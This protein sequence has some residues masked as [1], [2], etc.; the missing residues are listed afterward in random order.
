MCCNPLVTR[1]ATACKP[2]SVTRPKTF[3]RHI[4]ELCSTIGKRLLDEH[5]VLYVSGRQLET[6]I[7]GTRP[8]VVRSTT[9]YITSINDWD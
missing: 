5:R 6:V 4:Y 3:L 2:K 1:I 9:S 7:M 8:A